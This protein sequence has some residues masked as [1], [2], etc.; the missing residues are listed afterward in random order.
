MKHQ[1]FLVA[2]LF[3]SQPLN[4][5]SDF[6]KSEFILSGKIVGQMSGYLHLD[7]LNE[8][9]K[10]IRDS[11]L[12]NNGAFQFNGYINEPSH[13]YFYYKYG[14][15][16]NATEI[17]LEP[18]TMEAVFQ[19]NDFKNGKIKGSVSQNEF[20]SLQL[21]RNKITA[22]WKSTWNAFYSARAKN[23][24]V[25]AQA[26]ADQQLIFYDSELD[27]MDYHFIKQNA[28]SYVSANVLF[29]KNQKLT[30]DSLKMFYTILSSNVQNSRDGKQIKEFI[31]KEERVGIGKQAPDF[32]QNDMYGK[33]VSLKDFR[34]K[35]ILLEF[36]A[37]WCV[38]CRE[39]APYLIKAFN[40]YKEKNFT[41]IGVSIDKEKDKQA[42]IEAIK[43]DRLTWTQLSDLKGIN[44]EVAQ[45]YNVLPIPAN[46]LIDPNGTIITTNLRGENLEKKLQQVIK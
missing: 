33:H 30:L 11:C 29:Y 28:D 8:N 25:K 21:E 32:T 38:P 15:D 19:V 14:D 46:F 42:W 17:F 9:G 18:D 3:F 26:I 10:Y 12:L 22:K 31:N 41:I 44:N 4:A 16:S 7:Y 34:G 13:A 43:K 1:T 37:S 2:V 24:M 36:W 39:E 45:L 6:N 5:Q 23:D 35:F 20:T 27:S 40:K